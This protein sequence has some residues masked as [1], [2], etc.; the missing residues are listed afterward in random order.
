LFP[1]TKDSNLNLLGRAKDTVEGTHSHELFRRY[2]VMV[3]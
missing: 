3:V 2:V 1:T